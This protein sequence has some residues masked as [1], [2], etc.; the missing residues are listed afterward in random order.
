[1][2]NK[3]WRSLK[4]INYKMFIALLVVG[5]VPTIYTTVRI[6][7]LGQLPGE[8]SYSI[9][10]QLS[11]IN[12]IF[13]VVSEAIIL[14]LFFFIGKVIYDKKELTNRIKTGMLVTF[15]IYL[16]LSLLMIAFVNPLLSWMSVSP[17][18][19]K[20]SATYIRIEVVATIFSTLVSFGLVVL[21]TMKKEKYLYIFM[22]L[23]LVLCLISDTFLVSTLKFSAHMGVNGIGVSNILVN[24]LLLI[25]II[26]I[27]YREDIKLFAK[28][29][30]SFSWMRDFIKI[31]GIS[32]A[33]SLVRNLAYM[34]MICK[35]VNVVSEQG[36][37]WVANN[38][39][40][41]WLLL[42]ITQLAE[43]IKRD[44]SKDEKAIK[45]R[46]LGYLSITLIV[47]LLWCAT[48]PL[49]KPFMSKVLQYGDTDKLFSLVIIL[50]GFYVLYAF[51]NVFDSTFYGIG[52]TNYMLFESIVTN[53]IYYGIAFI[54]YK[55][56]VWVPTL[57]GIAIL[58]G[59]GMA[60]D[61]VVSLIA[62]I[63]LLKKKHISILDVEIEKKGLAE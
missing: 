31:G 61:S 54:L 4:N 1:M 28:E 60:F 50:L 63:F 55:T 22:G 47:C 6:F 62:Y 37:Y 38:F 58:F 18:I 59:V 30:L 29:K 34:V 57:T 21:T 56:G 52:K 3:I 15:L 26:F 32:G 8:W 17:D 10:G 19:M 45:N 12:L 53:S 41:G 9:A 51:Q 24:V 7:F 48:I 33:E 25:G 23:K 11:W 46:T 39:I 16:T 44:T 42:P 40:W 35:M 27:F 2:F 5:L 13:E 36:T 43:L 14:P 20:E 49:W